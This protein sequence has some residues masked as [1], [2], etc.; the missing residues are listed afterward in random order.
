MLEECGLPYTVNLLSYEA[1]RVTTPGFAAISPL[2]KFPA[3]TERRPDGGDHS[4][5]G[6]GAILWFLAER[7]GCLL[8]AAGEARSECQSWLMLVLT[9]FAPVTI[10]HFRF[11]VLAPERIDYAID[12]YAGEIERCVAVLDRRLGESAYLGGG[13]YSI[14]DI[15]AFPF[16]D[17]LHQGDT[18]LLAKWPGLTRWHSEVAARPA[19]QRGMQVPVLPD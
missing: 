8:P 3:L 18:A 16:I 1:G 6:S 11:N 14:A 13:D 2:S 17:S 12:L 4:V 19:V 9:D 7:A 15:A 10:G 5:F